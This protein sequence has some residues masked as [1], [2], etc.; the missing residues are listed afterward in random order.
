MRPA[1]KTNTETPEF[2]TSERCFITE[3]WNEK[4]DRAVSIARARGRPGVVTQW[5]RLRDTTERYL[6]VA[7]TGEV[8]VGDLGPRRVGPGDVVFIPPEVRQRISNDGDTDLVFFA[9]CTPSFRPEA[10]ETIE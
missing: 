7:G 10:Y 4:S 3:N 8:E 6:L 9:V 2:E 5:H 1:I